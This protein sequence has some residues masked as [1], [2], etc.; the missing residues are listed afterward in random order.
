MA[1]RS[2][3]VEH[4]NSIMLSAIERQ[5][6]EYESESNEIDIDFVKYFLACLLQLRDYVQFMQQWVWHS[7][8]SLLKANSL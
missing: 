2:E 6:K 4:Q 5:T 3:E 1:Q 7:R 8:I